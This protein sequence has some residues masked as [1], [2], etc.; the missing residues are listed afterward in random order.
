MMTHFR[1]SLSLSSSSKRVN[2][3]VLLIRM[4]VGTYLISSGIMGG[5]LSI[6]ESMNSADV[7]FEAYMAIQIVIG[8]LLV[9]GLFT[10]IGAVTLLGI[11]ASTFVVYGINALDQVMMLGI[12]LALLV[13]GGSKYSL[14]CLLFG[15][16]SAPKII[17]KKFAMIDANKLFLSSIR[18]AF[19]ANLI[20]LGLTEKMLAPDMFVAVMENFHLS[21]V[22]VESEMAAY[23]AGLIELAIGAFYLLGMRMRI[24]SSLMFGILIFTVVMFHESIVAHLIMFAISALFVINGK[25]PI[26]IFGI[27]KMAVTVRQIKNILLLRMYP[28]TNQT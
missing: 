2:T 25:D 4:A 12:C 23:G 5:L 13:K 26:T 21:P 22:G 15:K 14:D 6:V 11:F 19:G 3:S 8:T 27:S 18:M 28:D 17:Q 24:V 10:R 7:N 1:Q 20:W 16:T 9:T